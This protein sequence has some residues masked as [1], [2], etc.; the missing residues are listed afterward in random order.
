M[1][2]ATWEPVWQNLGMGKTAVG[3]GSGGVAS[4]EHAGCPR[5][6]ATDPLVTGMDRRKLAAKIGFP[7]DASTIPQARWM[8]A[9]TFENLVHSKAFAGR[10]VSEICG[11]LGLD[12]P[13]TVTTADAHRG[14]NRTQRLLKAAH[15]RAAQNDATIIYNAAVPFTVLDGYDP[16]NVLPDFLV[17]APALSASDSILVV[18]D[19]KD[20]E[21]HRARIDDSRLL[22]GFLQVAYGVICVSHWDGIPHGMAVSHFGALAIPRNTFLQPMAIVEDLADHLAEVEYRI[23]ERR[24][25]AAEAAP[26]TDPTAVSISHIAAKY[27]PSTCRT[28]SLF[29][30][31]RDQ[32]RRSGVPGDLLVEIGIPA[33]RRNITALPPGLDAQLKATQSGRGQWTGQRRVDAVGKRGTIELVLAKSDTSGVGV[34]GVSLRVITAAGPTP[35]AQQVFGNPIDPTTRRKLMSQLGQA[36]ATAQHETPGAIHI[37]VPDQVT[38]DILATIADNLAGVELTRLR[39]ERDREMGRPTLTFDGEPATVPKALR[40]AARLAVSFL[41]EED[42]SRAMRTRNPVINLRTVL[43]NH[44]VAGGPSLESGRLDYLV[45]WADPQTPVDHREVADRIEALEYTP[46]ARLTTANSDRIHESLM[47]GNLTQY[48]ELVTAELDYKQKVLERAVAVLDSV[49][50]SN[51]QPGVAALEDAAQEVWRSRELLHA[52]DLV[53]FGRTWRMWRNNLAESFEKDR[54]FDAQL[55]ALVNPQTAME[56]ALD[57]GMRE[58]ASATVTS[59]SPPL[60][61]RVDSR[62]FDDGD[63]IVLLAINGQVCAEQQNVSLTVQKGALKLTGFAIGPLTRLADDGAGGRLFEWDPAAPVSLAVGDHLIIAN[64]SW[65]SDAKK[66]RDLNIQRPAL[67]TQSAP[68]SDCELDSFSLDPDRHRYC[69]RPHEDFE[70]AQSDRIAQQRENGELNPQVWPP[71]RDDDAFDNPSIK[72]PVGNLYLDNP[73]EMPTGLTLDDLE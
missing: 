68:R 48:R 41:L 40:P 9:N 6:R 4:S 12:R 5:F 20:Y 2:H 70:A 64:F 52:S 71:V 29:A 53:R 59:E 65:F 39:L 17:V 56:L 51:L 26:L 57:T 19:A 72:S 24:R 27:D 36:L 32:L 37:V 44:L 60:E 35:W 11:E 10:I 38:S 66:N 16:T 30:F 47:G 21:R 34:H 62:R 3:G 22:K 28:C 46:G 7:D 1:F 63:R 8:R 33:A 61:I 54:G 55:Q 58:V 73:A 18:G 23:A 50:V 49:P 14:T 67:D 15:K 43:A 69:C 42:R 31:C 13:V 45:E 25:E